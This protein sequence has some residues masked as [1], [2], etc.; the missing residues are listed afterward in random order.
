MSTWL[1]THLTNRLHHLKINELYTCVKW[2]ILLIQQVVLEKISTYPVIIFLHW[3]CLQM[4]LA[5]DMNEA[6]SAICFYM[7]LMSILWAI[8]EYLNWDSSEQ[9]LVQKMQWKN[10]RLSRL[11]YSWLLHKTFHSFLYKTFTDI[12]PCSMVLIKSDFILQHFHVHFFNITWK[13][14]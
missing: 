4:R 13:F 7:V 2:C 5:A 14:S 12:P 8:L 6:E 9:N 10:L 1:Q 11:S 3:T